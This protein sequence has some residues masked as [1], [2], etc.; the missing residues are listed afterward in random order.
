MCKVSI[1]VPIYKVE[2][3]LESCL[4]S[5]RNQTFA[6]YEVIMVND[7]SPDNCEEICYRYVNIDKRFK[8]FKQENSGVSAARCLGVSKH[9]EKELLRELDKVITKSINN[10]NKIKEINS[11]MKRFDVSGV[12]ECWRS[13]LE[14]DF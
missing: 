7:G 10:K 1:I 5:I 12:V 9:E 13:L 3:Y 6:D 11:Y 2:Q 8:Y 14:G 4:E